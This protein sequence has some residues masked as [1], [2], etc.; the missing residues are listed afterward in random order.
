MEDYKTEM[1]A[2]I[3]Q[4]YEKNN[5]SLTYLPRSMQRLLTV[6]NTVAEHVTRS[7]NSCC[8]LQFCYTLQKQPQF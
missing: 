5:Q 7:K 1:Y 8:L 2:E 6:G 3:I 4:M